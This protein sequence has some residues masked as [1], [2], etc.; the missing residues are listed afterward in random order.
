[1]VRFWIDS[2]TLLPRRVEYDGSGGSSRLIEFESVQLNPDL[3]ASLYRVDLPGDVTV[4][5]GFS[6]L[7]D[8]DPDSS[9]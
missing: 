3:A 4:T 5:K 1:V 2:E 7:P 8:F 9:H 6:G